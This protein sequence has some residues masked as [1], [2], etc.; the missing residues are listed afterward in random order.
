[1][2]SNPASRCVYFGLTL[3]LYA[4]AIP[5]RVGAQEPGPDRTPLETA[6]Y[7][8]ERTVREWPVEPK[9]TPEGGVISNEE[10]Y[11]SDVA[12]FY[13]RL[14][15]PE[16]ALAV[17]RRLPTDEQTAMAT[18][19]LPPF[20]SVSDSSARMLLQQSLNS[21]KD[22]K[23]SRYQRYLLDAV[24]WSIKL[25]Q[26]E[27]AMRVADSFDD[28]AFEKP[29]ALALVA[30]HLIAAKENGRAEKLLDRAFKLA[31]AAANNYAKLQIGKYLGEIAA[32]YFALGK[33]GKLAVVLDLAERYSARGGAVFGQ[34]GPSADGAS[35]RQLVHTLI[36][37]HEFERAA[38]VLGEMRW[39]SNYDLCEIAE[40]FG[41]NGAVDQAVI[42]LERVSRELARPD[43]QDHVFDSERLYVVRA[44]LA[45][46]K[47][48]T[49]TRLA[50]EDVDGNYLGDEAIAVADWYFKAGKTALGLALL[51]S[52]RKKLITRENR[53]HGGPGFPSFELH[54]GEEVQ[55]L[56]HLADKY[57]EVKHFTEAQQAIEAITPPHIKA[58]KLVDL[59]RALVVAN[60]PDQ[61]RKVLAA[62]LPLA[63][64]TLQHEND[65][66]PLPALSNIAAV[67]GKLG[68]RER[69][70]QL[71]VQALDTKR[72]LASY[73]AL[74]IGVA[75]IGYY[76]ELSKLG[77]DK[78]I[79]DRLRAL[80]IRDKEKSI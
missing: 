53:F 51:D 47:I 69:A 29:A 79:S 40:A 31:Q 42:I 39:N 56:P 2:Y 14:E 4:T 36:R 50:R 20:Q 52:A 61:A 28:S 71:F 74:N 12:R 16:Q 11:R 65:I 44:Y 70:I 45:I 72:I 46:G 59:A 77:P 17:M 18:D 58:T 68:D 64:S 76:Y 49:A 33:F 48:D 57:L 9:L 34:F 6:W 25:G 67:Y 8:G 26:V 10:D 27:Q 37:G 55:W 19:M 66:Q 54:S 30:Q 62:A 60:Q 1:M 78:L 63:E 23:D 24:G 38:K 73:P 21:I 32:G 15:R 43:H 13:W 75:E 41:A 3:V 80:T 7:L 35:I 22:L 5:F